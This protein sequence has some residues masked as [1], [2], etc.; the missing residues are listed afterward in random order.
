MS[1]HAA[2][3]LME[4]TSISE[5][6]IQARFYSRY[7]ELTIIHIYDTEDTDEQI[8][9]EFYGRLQDVLDFV[10]EHNMLIVMGD[11]NAKV[12]NDNWA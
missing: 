2:A 6:V 8:K 4:W 1:K 12:E 7:I 3:S 10:N 11:M 9:D 5:R